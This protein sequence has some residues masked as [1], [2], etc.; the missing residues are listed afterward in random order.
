MDK[1]TNYKQL[2]A[3]QKRLEGVVLE[4]CPTMP[5]SSGIYFYTRVDEDGKHAYIGK[6]VDLIKRS[7]SHLQGYQRIDL[8]LRKRG[9]Y[10]KENESGWHL[11]F[12]LIP[13]N[14][15]DEKEAYY[16]KQYQGAGYELY[17][18]ESGGT[19]G[20]TIINERKG[21]KTYTE[22]KKEGKKQL[23]KALKDI[24][25]KY[26]VISLKKEGKLAESGLKKFWDLLSEED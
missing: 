8:S 25:D 21:P 10:S 9:F 7:V 17:N 18:I 6:A 26:L 19:T 3:I 13:Q 24:I 14:L 15:L 22:G 23:S 20:K 4:A 5:H 16:I 12:L 1:K 11:N 2:F